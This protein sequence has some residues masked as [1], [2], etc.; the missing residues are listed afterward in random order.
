MKRL[1][2]SSMLLVGVCL[3]SVPLR[4]EQVAPREIWPQAAAAIDS[5]DV[6]A[7][8]KKTSELTDVGKTY[9]IKTFPL[10][11][12]SAAS[13]AR[14]AAKQKNK[15]AV[16]WGNKSADRLDPQSPGVAFARADAAADQKNWGA[17]ITM[18]A[19][20]F[21]N[22]F[23]NYRSRVLSRSDMLVVM[24]LAIALTAAV[25]GIALFVRYGRAMAHDFRE[26]LGKRIRGGAVSVLAFA[27]LFLP[28]FLWLGPVWLVFYWFVI[29]F[30]YATSGERI[31]I[32]L[33]TILAGLAPIVLDE[34]SNWIAG[35]DGPVVMSAIASQ[36]RSYHPEALR[37]LQELV[38]IVP[39]DPMLHLLLGNLYL[40]DA[41]EQQASQHYRRSVELRDTAGAHVNLGNL[42]F[43]NNDFAAAITEYEKAEGLDA[44]LAIAF[45][46]HS[47]AS[48]ETYKF[49]EQ[50]K[51]LDQAKKIDR[52]DIERISSNPSAQ[53]V[54]MY[55]PPIPQAWAVS[56]RIARSGVAR[57]LFGNWAWFDP[58]QS[59]RNPMT[60]AALLT[61]IAAPL[62]FLRRRRTGLAGSCIKCGRT[63]CHRCKSARESA[64]YCTQ[65]I[66]IYLKRDGVSLDT[67]RSKLEEVSDHHNGMLRRNRMFATFLPGSAQLIEGRTTSGLLGVFV[68]LFFISLAVLVGRLAPVLTPGQVAQMVVRVLAVVLALIMWFVMTLPIYRRRAVG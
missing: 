43:F 52:G 15:P 6:N 10:Y 50:A 59:A 66:H 54:A 65:C 2:V 24:M 68:F 8:F 63:F 62:L 48:G 9:G 22:I 58:I 39:D 4:A 51:K 3:G 17:A 45:Y 34:A 25:L 42:H 13:L 61:L 11:A 64:T 44:R 16:D 36:E 29:F 12:E 56:S 35:V 19:R 14:Q 5:G 7:A 30:S 41:N 20:G 28:V 18:A 53:K 55:R 49:D 37:R 33:M 46:N 32:V 1:L 26:F 60:I 67:K 40:Q 27:L 47:I 57:T 38:N 31:A 23:R 21:S